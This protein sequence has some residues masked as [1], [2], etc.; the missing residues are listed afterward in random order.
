MTSK[1]RRLS[2]NAR[3]DYEPIALLRRNATHHRR[4]YSKTAKNGEQ[5]PHIR[6]F[7][8]TRLKGATKEPHGDE[9]LFLLGSLVL[10]LCSSGEVKRLSLEKWKLDMKEDERRRK[11][12]VFR[13]SSYL[14]VYLFIYLII[15]ELSAVIGH[16]KNRSKISRKKKFISR[17]V[18]DI[19]SFNSIYYT[20]CYFLGF[21]QRE[22]FI[23]Y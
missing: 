16:L 8:S 11:R 13:R 23:F 6:E 1:R 7:A 18:H 3:Y 2:Y 9:S 14:F 19:F 20:R 22:T 12:N 17:H 5:A 4:F 15:S 10:G 21:W